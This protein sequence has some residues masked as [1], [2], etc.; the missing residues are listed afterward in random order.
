ML[1]DA[2]IKRII[3][4]HKVTFTQCWRDAFTDYRTKYK[5]TR[6]VHSPLARAVLL[7]DHCVDHVVRAFDGNPIVTCRVV[8]GLFRV[9]ISGATVGVKGSITCRMKKLNRKMLTSNIP[10]QQ[11]LDFEQQKPLQYELFGE[12]LTKDQPVHINIGYWPN[13]LWTEPEGVYSTLPNGRLSIKWALKI[14]DDEATTVIEMPIEQKRDEPKRVT[15][16]RTTTIID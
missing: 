1:S 14:S 9:E 4:P 2:D 15:L 3:E 8:N 10:T 6:P 16:K 5:K 11:A 13:K 7:R 12:P